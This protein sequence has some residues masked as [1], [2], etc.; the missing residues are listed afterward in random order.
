MVTNFLNVGC[1][2]THVFVYMFGAAALRQGF[3]IYQAGLELQWSQ[4]CNDLPASASQVL[5]YRIII[6]II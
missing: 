4:T 1:G 6:L 3:A 5:G 2:N